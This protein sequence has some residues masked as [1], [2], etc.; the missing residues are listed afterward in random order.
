M[1]CAALVAV[2][3]LDAGRP[4]AVTRSSVAALGT[5]DWPLVTNENASMPGTSATAARAGPR[6]SCEQQA[7]VAGRHP[8]GAEGHVGARLAVDVGDAVLVVEQS[9]ARVGRSDSSVRAADRLEVLGEVVAVDV[10]VGD[11]AAQ[12]RQPV[13]QRELVARL[14]GGR[15]PAVVAGR[16]DVARPCPSLVR[17]PV[18]SA[19]PGRHRER[20]QNQHPRDERT[21]ERIEYSDA[22]SPP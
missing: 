13:V 6:P 17:P 9:Q 21:D 5:N 22:R 14:V 20:A 11:V 1:I 10:G 19:D 2:G 18:P 15:Q 7:A 16:Q 3:L 4:A 8:A 12:R